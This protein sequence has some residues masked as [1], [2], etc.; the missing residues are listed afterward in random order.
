MAPLNF[1]TFIAST[2]ATN[3]SFPIHPQPNITITST[4]ICTLISSSNRSLAIYGDLVAIL[5]ALTYPFL[6]PRDAGGQ[7]PAATLKQGAILS[8]IVQVF[9]WFPAWL[10]GEYPSVTYASWVFPLTVLSFVV[11]GREQGDDE[12]DDPVGDRYMAM[13]GVHLA[14]VYPILGLIGCH[15]AGPL[16]TVL[17][18]SVVVVAVVLLGLPD[19]K[20]RTVEVLDW[21][22]TR[23]VERWWWLRDGGEIGEEHVA[24]LDGVAGFLTLAQILAFV[25]F[26]WALFSSRD[27]GDLLWQGRAALPEPGIWS[28]CCV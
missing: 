16:R 9:S 22:A 12:R 7:T 24:R 26:W 23:R 13:A 18:V 28:C 17:Q 2:L 1:T 11:A 27:V 10:N 6:K 8:T 3:L 5:P 19:L 4:D 14:A 21:I 15:V 25:L 20:D